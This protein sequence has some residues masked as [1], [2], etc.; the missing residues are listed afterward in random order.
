M[1]HTINFD[2]NEGPLEASKQDNVHGL[3]IDVD[4]PVY[5][6]PRTGKQTH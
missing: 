1:D 4:S 5:K 6:N 3:H 2:L